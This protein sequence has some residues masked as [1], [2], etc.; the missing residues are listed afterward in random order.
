MSGGGKGD[1]P[2]N[3]FSKQYKNNYD[4]IKWTAKKN[5]E[6]QKKGKKQWSEQEKNMTKM[7]SKEG[8]NKKEI[9]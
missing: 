7:I 9:I 4:S 3:C 8:D 2:R 1:S 5:I 6:I